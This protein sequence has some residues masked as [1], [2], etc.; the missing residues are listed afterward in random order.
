M[1]LANMSQMVRL[2]IRATDESVPA[3][4]LKLMEQ[5]IS[6]GVSKAPM[7]QEGPTRQGITDAFSNVL[8]T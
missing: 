5:R 1:T 2:T 6:A 4:L 3:V 8:V 7:G